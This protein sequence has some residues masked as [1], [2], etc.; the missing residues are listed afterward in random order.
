MDPPHNEQSRR[1]RVPEGQPSEAMP[2]EVLSH[3]NTSRGT[4]TR[5]G[6]SIP[7]VLSS[8]SLITTASGSASSRCNRWGERGHLL[9][10]LPCGPSTANDYGHAAARLPCVG[11]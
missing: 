5:F 6:T 2:L 3:P 7:T 11:N 10:R 9:G 4:S 1:Q 8:A